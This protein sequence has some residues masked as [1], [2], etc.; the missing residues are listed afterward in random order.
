LPVI[1]LVI[2]KEAILPAVALVITDKLFVVVGGTLM[3]EACGNHESR[4][5]GQWAGVIKNVLR[6][7]VTSPLLIAVVFGAVFMYAG[8]E[9]LQPL[10]F[11]LNQF[12]LATA[13][14][15]LVALGATLSGYQIDRE[16]MVDIS[17]LV[18]LKSFLFPLMVF[19]MGYYVF[20]LPKVI[21]E[22][23]LIMAATPIAT[24]VFILASKYRVHVKEV[25]SGMLFTTVLS[26]FLI[27]A[28][29]I[30]MH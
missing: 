1:V 20:D 22:V 7:V 18:V 8:W 6:A 12:A 21:L 17:Q 10:D 11:F 16:K 30:V 19:L 25:S 3:L 14:C 29:L 13:P 27:S 28:I 2:G 5:S 24:N 9:L 15:A 26:I 23:S 4:E